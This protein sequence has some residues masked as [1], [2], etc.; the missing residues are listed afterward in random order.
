MSTRVSR[1]LGPNAPM[2]VHSGPA[3]LPGAGGGAG[4]LEAPGRCGRRSTLQSPGDRAQGRCPLWRPGAGARGCPEHNPCGPRTAHPPHTH[5]LGTPT[6]L[7]GQREPLTIHPTSGAGLRGHRKGPLGPG[8]ACSLS[9]V[10]GSPVLTTVPLKLPTCS[11]PILPSP[12]TRM[13]ILCTD[14]GRGVGM[15]G[16]QSW[17]SRPTLHRGEQPGGGR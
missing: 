6:P 8:E 9:P 16:G 2:K 15:A 13:T 11:L 4:T 7:P 17:R 14:P 12:L 1:F 3:C 10:G 5:I